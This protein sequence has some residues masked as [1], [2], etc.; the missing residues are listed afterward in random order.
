MLNSLNASG[1]KRTGCLDTRQSTSTLNYTRVHRFSGNRPV[2]FYRWSSTWIGSHEHWNKRD[3]SVDN[4]LNLRSLDISRLSI[5]TTHERR[6]YVYSKWCRFEIPLVLSLSPG[7]V[8]ARRRPRSYITHVPDARR[9][10]VL[11]L[12]VSGGRKRFMA[13]NDNIGLPIVTKL[14]T[15]YVALVEGLR[16]MEGN[17]V[18]LTIYGNLVTLL[19]TK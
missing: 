5:S 17:I 1:I 7:T 15:I 13:W 12:W 16:R 10:Q 14:T 2:L 19:K 3:W 8:G 9:G 18:N 4:P 11:R 6:L